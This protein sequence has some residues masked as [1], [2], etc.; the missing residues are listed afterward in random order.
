MRRQLRSTQE[1]EDKAGGRGFTPLGS[2]IPLASLIQALAVAEH[3]NFRHAAAALGASQSSVSQ[4]IKLLEQ[5]LGI[6]L[7]E[8]HP[9]G[10]RLTEAGR[11]F[12]EQVATGIDHLDHAVKTAGMI[13]SGEEGRIRI[14]LHSPL[15]A[16][17]LAD[18]I[19]R[20]REHRP[21]VDIEIAEGRACEAVRQVREGRLDVAFVAGKAAAEDCHSR[22]LWTEVL[23]VAVAAGHAVAHLDR[24]TWADLT[25]ETFLVRYGGAGPQ[26]HDHVA[27][28]LSDLGC[29]PQICRWDVGRDTLLH[30]VAQGY[31]VMLT[32]EATAMAPIPG[33]AFRPIID[34]PEPVSFS[35]VWSPHNRSRA[36]R[37]LLALASQ[38]SRS[39][40]SA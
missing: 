7:F 8:R 29:N 28:R 40:L 4:R 27:R 34:E 26:A 23:V 37:D 10:V 24:V 39:R 35:A 9:R 32:T 30:M 15:A 14:G 3:L 2:R 18:L 17:F 5:D 12:V 21:G 6:L 11:H 36:L 22:L 38:A 31:G 19:A 1:G 13:A 25:K 33:V 20:H 16:G